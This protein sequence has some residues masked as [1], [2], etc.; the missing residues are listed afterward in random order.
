MSKGS[1]SLI[2]ICII[3]LTAQINSLTLAPLPIPNSVAL[4]PG[5][6]QWDYHN[7]NW[8]YISKLGFPV[9]I[10]RNKIPI[11][12]NWTY[13]FPLDN[14]SQYHVYFYGG[15]INT[16]T[17][18]DIFV[19]DPSGN[20]ETYHTESCGLPEHLG[21]TATH[22]LFNPK[23]DGNYSIVIK[24]DRYDS[25]LAENGTLMV[26]EH[27]DV[28]R[29]YRNKLFMEGKDKALLYSY[30]MTGVYEFNSSSRHIEVYVDVPSTLDMYEVR[31]YLMADPAS[32]LGSNLVGMPISWE[33]GLYNRTKQDGTQ[34]VGGY[35]VDFTPLYKGNVFDSCE[36]FGEDMFINYTAPVSGNLLYHLVFI[37]EWGYGNVS[38]LLKTDFTKPSLNVTKPS[39]GI[40]EVGTTISAVT[41]DVSSQ[42]D[43]V[44]MSYSINNGVSWVT[45]AMTE[46]QSNHYSAVIPGQAAGT[47][48]QYKVE[49]WD[50]AWNKASV[51]GIYQVKGVSNVTLSLVGS[52]ISGG[53]SAVVNGS[54][55]PAKSNV[56]VLVRYVSPT[57]FGV[58]RTVTTDLSGNF[59]DSYTPNMSGFWRVY[60]I[61]GGD[62]IYSGALNSTFLTVQK[63]DHTLNMSVSGDKATLGDT[64]TINGVLSPFVQGGT[65]NIL[66]NCPN[67]STNTLKVVTQSSGTYSLSF[68]VNVKG[69]WAVQAYYEGNALHYSAATSRLT[70]EA[71]ESILGWVMSNIFIIVAVVAVVAFVAYF[72]YRRS[73][74]E[75]EGSQRPVTL[76]RLR[77]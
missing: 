76:R 57:G 71:Q 18:Y 58:N 73:K 14:D 39:I 5:L 56:T 62:S 28:N 33:A 29:W 70:F 36:A 25:K 40:S 23:K 19:Y 51:S 49:S 66:V 47:T 8:T 44:N 21:T 34:K 43:C 16:T 4:E 15:W 35:T 24:N 38:F 48:V 3:I 77:Q 74:G 54:I 45:M 67:G 55:V 64:Y 63:V 61:W 9:N 12:Q 37:S 7:G 59:V 30:N 1:F 2:I 46:D 60:A 72:L 20:R 53:T 10:T 11:G 32:R 69:A 50:R 27:L 52:V 65:I 6:L 17:D 31:L 68:K 41:S 26:V 75:D 42:I 13:V 22:P